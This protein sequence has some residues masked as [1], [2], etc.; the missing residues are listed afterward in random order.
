MSLTRTDEVTVWPQQVSIYCTID[1]VAAVFLSSAARETAMLCINGYAVFV[2]AYF[3]LMILEPKILRIPS[4]W[5]H[6]KSSW[7]QQ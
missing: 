6:V 2:T 3:K 5:V 4:R 1:D 7:H